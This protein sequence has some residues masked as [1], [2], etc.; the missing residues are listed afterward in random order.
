MTP[1]T[2]KI[3]QRYWYVDSGSKRPILMW[4][5]NRASFFDFMQQRSG[6]CF[7]IRKDAKDA[8]DAMLIEYKGMELR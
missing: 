8:L 5:E 6:N 4:K 2:P 3:G 7:R 1:F